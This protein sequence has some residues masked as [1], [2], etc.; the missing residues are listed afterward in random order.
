M[1]NQRDYLRK[2]AGLAF[3][4]KINENHI[5]PLKTL[6]VESQLINLFNTALQNVRGLKNQIDSLEG[7]KDPRIPAFASHQASKMK[8]ENGE[9]DKVRLLALS[10][11]KLDLLESAL[12]ECFGHE[13]EDHDEYDDDYEE[14][15]YDE[16]GDD[17]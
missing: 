9:I 12:N 2:A 13:E 10:R 7:R 11:E 15:D 5:S 3:E 6:D 4:K 1:G 8:L 17:I 16:Y 14:D